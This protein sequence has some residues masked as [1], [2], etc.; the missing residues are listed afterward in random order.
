MRRSRSCSVG[1]KLRRSDRQKQM[2]VAKQAEIFQSEARIRSPAMLD[3]DVTIVEFFDYHC[4]YCRS[5]VGGLRDLI[6]ADKRLRF[7]FKEFPVLGP[8]SMTAARA[9]LAAKQQ[10]SDKYYDFHIALM[11]APD[12]SIETIERLAGESGL[13]VARL[14]VDMDGEAV[15]RTIEANQA[16]AQSLGINGTPSFVVGDKLIPGAVD[17]KQLAALVDQR[18][19]A[20]N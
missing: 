15:K 9:A 13:D 14:R 20:T 5:M 19:N 10:D 1:G 3:G 11:G 12:L 4:G 6:Q 8:D 16:L 2:I 18:R 17:V 7:V